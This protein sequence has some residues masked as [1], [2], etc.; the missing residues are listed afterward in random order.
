MAL[1]LS[2]GCDKSTPPQQRLQVRDAAVTAETRHEEFLKQQAADLAR[3]LDEQRRQT[4]PVTLQGATVVL[5]PPSYA[6][7]DSILRALL[8]AAGDTA[9]MAGWAFEER[10]GPA[11]RFVE[12]G[13]G[14]RYEVP[15]ETMEFGVILV[16]PGQLPQVI[17]GPPSF[18]Q[19]GAR[20]RGLESWLPGG[21]PTPAAPS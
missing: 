9:R 16:A 5:Y 18:P 8:A 4:G 1:L 11:V 6:V 2:I 7:G 13:S 20:L 21:A 14:A 10:W 15:V 17:V 3:H 19:L 12:S